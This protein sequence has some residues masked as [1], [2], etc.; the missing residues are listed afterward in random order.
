MEGG[1]EAQEGLKASLSLH[2]FF[3]ASA[4]WTLVAQLFPSC[5]FWPNAL[6]QKQ[7]PGHFHLGGRIPE[8]HMVF[9]WESFWELKWS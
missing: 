4:P 7:V 6:C 9:I 5:T 3:E 8:P 2:L 1:A